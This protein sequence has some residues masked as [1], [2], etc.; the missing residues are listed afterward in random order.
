MKLMK[1]KD[2]QRSGKQSFPELSNE[3]F[4]FIETLK[5]YAFIMRK[6]CNFRRKPTKWVPNFR[7]KF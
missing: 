7:R 1:N 3:S 2:F 6:V 4:N 5:A